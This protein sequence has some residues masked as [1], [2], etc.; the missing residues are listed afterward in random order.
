VEKHQVTIVKNL[1][2][3]IK[4]IKEVFYSSELIEIGRE[5]KRL[6]YRP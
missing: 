3:F 6:G 1:D 5:A 2:T 4:D